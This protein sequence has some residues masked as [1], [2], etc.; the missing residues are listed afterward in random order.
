MAIIDI[1]LWLLCKTKSKASTSARCPT[2]IISSR[3]LHASPIQQQGGVLS[4]A[5]KQPTRLHSTEDSLTLV[6]ARAA[7]PP[8]PQC[9]PSSSSAAA[10]ASTTDDHQKLATTTS[11]STTNAKSRRPPTSLLPFIFP[12]RRQSPLL[13]V[14]YPMDRVG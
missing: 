9:P 1:I 2:I 10:A 8:S 4:Q 5:S 12:T 13:S 14:F 11:K 6:G 7:P 3:I